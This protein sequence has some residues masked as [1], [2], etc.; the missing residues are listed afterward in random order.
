MAKVDANSYA[1][2]L[3]PLVEEEL[4]KREKKQEVVRDGIRASKKIVAFAPATNPNKTQNKYT[5][6]GITWEQLRVFADSYPIARACI[7]YRISQ[8]TQLAWNVAPTELLDDADED[9]KQ[10]EVSKEIKKFLKFPLGTRDKTL[11]SFLTEVIEDVLV[12][13]AVAI[14]RKYTLGG[15]IIGWRPFDPT[16]IELMLMPD[17]STPIPPKPAY[18]HKVNGVEVSKLT[19]DDMYYRMMHPRTNS[20]YGLSPLETLAI[21]VT[22]ALKLQSYNLGY[23]TEGNVPE[24]FVELPKDVASNPDQLKE[25]QNAWDAIFSGDPRYQR[26]LKFL[27]E[28]MKYS[29]TKKHEDM[30]FERFEKWL[31]LNTCAVFGVSPQDLGFTFDN[32]KSQAETQWEIG[33]ERGLFPLAQFIKELIDE[34]I[35]Q[36]LNKEDFEFIWTNLNPTNKLEE[37][38]TFQILVNSGAVSIDEWRVAEGYRP[39]GAPHYISTPIGPIFVKDLVEQS[40]RGLDPAMPY[41]QSASPIKGGEAASTAENKSGRADTTNPETV[42]AQAREEATGVKT[43]S[44]G[45]KADGIDHEKVLQDL[46]KW[47]KAAKNDFKLGKEYRTFY[48]DSISVR[49]QELIKYGLNKAKNIEEINAIFEPFLESGDNSVQSLKD[50]YGRISGIIAGQV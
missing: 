24:G 22:T 40:D 11:R 42:R 27:P 3:A 37:A 18:L 4:E 5:P 13:D 49:N 6:Y 33:K 21:V 15:D 29:A 25:W 38:K 12:L 8:I 32:G 43:G 7:N 19:T 2:L 20:P 46:R 1:D 17:G 16:T 26:K 30:T 50:L 36:D 45:R 47:K 41:T 28:G 34:M 44:E 9:K 39:I 14:E 31:L 10:R 48:T 23:L 35:Q